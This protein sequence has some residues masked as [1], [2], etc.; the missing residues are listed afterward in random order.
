[1]VVLTADDDERVGGTIERGQ[2]LEFWRCRPRRVFLVH[3]IE[4][5]QLQ[6]D[7][8]DE[9]HLMTARRQCPLDEPRDSDALAIHPYRP[10]EHDDS[11]D[12][13]SL[14]SPGPGD[15]AES[16]PRA[17][18]PGTDSPVERREPLRRQSRTRGQDPRGRGA[19]GAAARN[20]L[21][22]LVSRQ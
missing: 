21:A 16:A 8:I 18:M 22:L 2:L 20:A 1:V 7:W 15:R 14:P 11:H 5:R 4:Q 12:V 6:L 9:R 19:T 10:D 17:T 13:A 3:P